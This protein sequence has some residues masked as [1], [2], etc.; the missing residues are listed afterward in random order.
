MHDDSSPWFVIDRTA[1]ILCDRCVRGCGEVRG[2]YVLARAGKGA[3]ARIAFDWE[4]AM[5]ESSCVK[6]GECFISCPTNAI[7]M[8]PGV[9][10]SPWDFEGTEPAGPPSIGGWLGRFFGS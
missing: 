9:K 4:Q 6:C 8:K 3:E 5:G 7:T 1:C 10:P 2:H